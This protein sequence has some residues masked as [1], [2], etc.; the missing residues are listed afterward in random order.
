MKSATVLCVLALMVSAASANLVMNSGFEAMSG[1]PLAPENWTLYAGNG[2]TVYFSAKTDV[3]YE[4]LYSEKVAAR[5][6]YGMI[7]QTISGFTGGQSLSLWLY[8]RGD[9]NS[10]WQMDEAGDKVDVSIKFKDAG[11]VQIGSEISMVLFDADEATEAQLLSKTEWLKSPV[12][13]FVTPGNT[14]QVQIKIRS[15]DGTIDGNQGD[16]TGV[17]LDAITLVPEPATMM[18]LGLGGLVGLCRRK[19]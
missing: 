16:G 14:A 4:G 12:F 7:H 2:A 8:G 18:L 10:S 19:R 9:T 5:Q 13:N 15:V 11:G 3:V 1:S 6:G 17:Y